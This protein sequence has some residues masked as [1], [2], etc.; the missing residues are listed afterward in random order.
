MFASALPYWEVSKKEKEFFY[1][2]LKTAR[3]EAGFT[4]AEVAKKLKRSRSHISKVELGL[5]RLFMDEFLVLYRLYGKPTVYFYSAF[6]KSN[7]VERQ[8]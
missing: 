8:D 5:R 6:L 4:Q 7:L 1:R 3:K 2:A